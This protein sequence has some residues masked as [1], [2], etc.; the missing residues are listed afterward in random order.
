MLGGLPGG[1]MLKLRFD[2]YIS[3]LLLVWIDCFLT[4][5][6][7]QLKIKTTF[8][9]LATQTGHKA[10][11]I[12]SKSFLQVKMNGDT[13]KKKHNHRQEYKKRENSFLYPYACACV[14][15]VSKVNL[16][17][18]CFRQT[19]LSVIFRSRLYAFQYFWKRIFFLHFFL[20]LRSHVAYSNYFSFLHTKT[21]QQRHHLGFHASVRTKTISQ[22]FQKLHVTQESVFGLGADGRPSRKKKLSVCKHKRM[23]VNRQGLK[24]P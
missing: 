7:W 2:R 13:D 4:L 22:C 17:H 21:L 9:L 10:S 12:P 5:Y 8:S 11:L 24:H 1:G 18:L 6:S 14:Q 3:T 16:L 23:R 20:N 15:T 19:R